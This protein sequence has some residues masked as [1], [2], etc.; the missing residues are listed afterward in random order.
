MTSYKKKK[1]TFNPNFSPFKTNNTMNNIYM[2]HNIQ[3][4]PKNCNPRGNVQSPNLVPQRSR[5]RIITTT[6]N[7]SSRSLGRIRD[8]IPPKV[9]PTSHIHEGP[10]PRL[11]HSMNLHSQ[12]LGLLEKQTFLWNW[13]KRVKWVNL[14]SSIWG[15]VGGVRDF[16]VGRNNS[17]SSSSGT[18]WCAWGNVY[19]E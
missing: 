15:S 13:G 19:E 4:N 2:I 8:Q 3:T 17:G 11:Y 7:Q 14:G 5:N 10:K 12:K 6:Y 1:A 9:T 18:C 16:G